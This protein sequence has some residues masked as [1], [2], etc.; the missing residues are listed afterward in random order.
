M[1]PTKAYI[2]TIDNPISREY[3]K[4]CADSCDAVG[5]AWEYFEG[6]T[7]ISI[8]ESWLRTG[9]N[10]PT[11]QMLTGNLRIDN[12]QCCSAGHAAIWKKI[13]EGNE[14][15]IVLEHD[16][17]MLHN[18]NIDI[19]DNR[20]VVLGYKTQDPSKYDHIT[21]GPPKRVVDLEAHEG[22]HAYA[23]TPNTAK[24]MVDEIEERGILGCI[25]NAYFIKRQRITRT[26]LA[27]M[28]PTP[29]IG[30]LRE[31]TLWKKSATANY[32]FIA[33]FSVNYK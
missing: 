17:L 13:S 30:W 22:A 33:S 1:I 19:P 31:S 12:T 20:I 21:A 15:A 5:L 23:L 11:L 29:A 4:T 18:L 24:A 32:D 3:A 6:Y 9:I 14:A 28:D 25:D 8:Y 26:P 10:T 2:L 27:I 16:A 7:N